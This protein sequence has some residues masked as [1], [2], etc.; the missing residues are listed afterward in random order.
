VEK[1]QAQ[2]DELNF[3]E[4]EFNDLEEEKANLES[5]I[6]DLSATVDT[7]SAQLEGRLRFNYKDPVKGFDRSKVKGLVAKLI[8]VKDSKHSTALE[9]AAGGKLFQV[10]VDEDITGKALLEKGKLERRVT[11]IPLNKIRSKHV[12][13]SNAMTANSIAGQLKTTATPAIE[14]VGF[15]E[16]VRSAIEYVF[17]STIVVDG[18]KAANEIC[19]A[20]KTRTVTLEGD[21]YD[22]SGTISGGSKDKIGTTLTNLT[23]LA[24][25]TMELEKKRPQLEKVEAQL[26]DMQKASSSFDKLS[27]KLELAQA[28]LEAAAKQLSQTNYGML[29]ERRDS[30]TAELEAAKQECVDMEKEKEEKWQLFEKLQKD[31]GE[32]TM[33]RERKLEE[34]EE[35]VKA[36]KIEASDKAKMAREAESRAQ[37]LAMEVESLKAEVS[38]AEE[39]VVAAEKALDDATGEEAESQMRVGEIQA[40]Y[41]EARLEL[42]TLEKKVDSF[43]AEIVG[44]KREKTDLV[45]AAEAAKLAAKKL[46]VQI[47]SIA[48]EWA[49][50]E[51][52]VSVMLKK[53]P[54][55]ESE[56]SAFGVV[57]GDYDFEAT[58][59]T[60]A[61]EQLKELK[62]EQE[63]LVSS[64]PD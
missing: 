25:A 43:S 28:E 46:S 4:S 24:E 42:D 13:N 14:L 60:E 6:S 58:D 3:S 52:V 16:E 21:V 44:L 36:A 59:P 41:E 45:K 22:P 33:Q 10:V 17:G 62:A 29:I 5:S 47:A 56:M 26:R 20:T 9:V 32:L 55:I 11:I 50:A 12:S 64:R 53:H 34:L 30:M 35:A 27:A 2:L 8:Q 38:S 1:A 19:D 23:K 57:G 54:W 40:Q 48:K 37:T 63:S 51:K 15:D 31:E 18:M 61:T 49:S 7:L 39:A